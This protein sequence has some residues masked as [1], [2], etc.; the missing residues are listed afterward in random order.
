MGWGASGAHFG[1]VNTFGAHYGVLA[2]EASASFERPSKTQTTATVA[3][4]AADDDN[5]NNNSS[6]EVLSSRAAA[7]IAVVLIPCL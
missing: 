6:R 7:Q 4:T 3:G 5:N 2:P 1:N